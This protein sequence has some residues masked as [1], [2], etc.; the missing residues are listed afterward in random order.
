M[1]AYRQIVAADLAFLPGILPLGDR[2]IPVEAPL[3]RLKTDVSGWIAHEGDARV[4]YALA[5]R[6]E[7]ELL[8]LEVTSG[9]REGVGSELLRQAEAWLYSH[10]WKEIRFAF[11]AAQMRGFFLGQGWEDVDE[12]AGGLRLRKINPDE[13]FCLEEHV[14]TDAATGISRLVR[15]QRGPGDQPHRLGL[16]LDGEHYWRDLKVVPLLNALVEAGEI[17]RM[18]FAFVG[19]VSAA[20]RHEDYTG[21]ERYSRFLEDA[22]VGWL[23]EEMPALQPNGHLIAGLSLSGLMATYQTVAFP[24]RFGLCLSQSGSHWWRPEEFADLVRQKTPLHA[25]FWLSVGDHETQTGVAHPPTGLFQEISQIDGVERA[26]R[27]LE[28]AG[29][30]VRHHCFPGEHSAK[31]WREELPDALRWLLGESP[32]VQD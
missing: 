24:L 17:P 3:E 25:K 19:H 20:A 26:G 29:A 28:E 6:S 5:S 13:A 31:C 9:G 18:T 30:T 27:V 2:K 14:I 12:S 16:F 8:A 7:G 21:N 32:P 22:V 10:G 11:P 4:G 1:I 23:R 15:L